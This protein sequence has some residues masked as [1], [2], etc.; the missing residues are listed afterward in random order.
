M[1]HRV[2]S[3]QKAS[4]SSKHLEIWGL[5]RTFAAENIAYGYNDSENKGNAVQ[6]DCLSDGEDER[7]EDQKILY[8]GNGFV[9]VAE[10]ERLRERIDAYPYLIP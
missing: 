5:I 6:E 3:S 8:S 9:E 7:V 1:V 4:F 10:Q 2:I